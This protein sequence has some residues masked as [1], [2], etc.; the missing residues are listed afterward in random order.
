MIQG[1]AIKYDSYFPGFPFVV[2]SMMWNVPD[3][4]ALIGD[5]FFWYFLCEP[6][7]NVVLHEVHVVLS[8]L[9]ITLQPLLQF[10]EAA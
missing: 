8:V 3:S 5:F 1:A 9:S 10:H 6:V 4:L 2:H 7:L